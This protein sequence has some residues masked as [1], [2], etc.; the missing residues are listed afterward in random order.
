V[1][2]LEKTSYRWLLLVVAVQRTA[3]RYYRYQYW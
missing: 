2:K 3:L 1:F